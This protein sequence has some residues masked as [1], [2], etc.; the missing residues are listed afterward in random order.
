MATPRG[1]EERLRARIAELEEEVA[2]LRRSAAEPGDSSEV[3]RDQA[4][5][6]IHH[7]MDH[8]PVGF[9]FFDTDLRYRAV[10]QKLAEIDGLPAE[11]H[12]GRRVEEVIPN[13]ARRVRQAFEHVMATGQPV[14]DGLASGET[15]SAP[16]QIRH[17]S[18]S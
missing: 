6:L 10:N 4:V 18:A 15:P 7:L 12:I 17:W 14:L 13:L 5:A 8:A 16:G 1:D 3:D 9:V 2:S 11:D